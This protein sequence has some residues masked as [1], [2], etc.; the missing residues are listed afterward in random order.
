MLF[1]DTIRYNIRYGRTGASDEEVEEAARLAHIHEAIVRRF[2]GEGRGGAEGRG[3][4]G[5]EWGD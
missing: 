5:G 3:V 4:A 1:H 2:P